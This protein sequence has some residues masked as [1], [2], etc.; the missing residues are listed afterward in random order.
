MAFAY[1]GASDSFLCP[2]G[3]RLSR[4]QVMIRDKV[5]IYAARPGDC[6]ACTEK[7]ACTQ[8]RQRC[9]SRHFFEDA[10][11]DNARRLA[12]HP[13]MM[14]IR[15]QTVEHPFGTIKFQILGNARLL[16]RGILGAKAELSLAVLAYNFKRACNMKGRAWMLQ[17]LAA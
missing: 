1:D 17:T 14:V 16:M 8:A 10:L 9:V 6:A 7:P 4:K 2:T 13:E 11:S 12:S 15:R 3:K 5:V